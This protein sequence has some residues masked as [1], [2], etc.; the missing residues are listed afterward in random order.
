MV[1]NPFL[2]HLKLRT[3]KKVLEGLL[4]AIFPILKLKIGEGWDYRVFPC[5]SQKNRV[6][7]ILHP[8]FWQLWHRKTSP[9]KMIFICI[10]KDSRKLHMLETIKKLRPLLPEC[11]YLLGN[12]RFIGTTYIQDRVQSIEE[13]FGIDSDSDRNEILS[14]LWDLNEKFYHLGFYNM[15]VKFSNYGVTCLGEIILTDLSEI[16]FDRKKIEEYR[17]SEL[18]GLN[19]LKL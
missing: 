13:F 7:K 17:H 4:K 15:N 1:L 16:S 5:R 14:E 8:I 10:S 18:H 2:S 12:P 3:M 11:G 19:E 9:M 6:V